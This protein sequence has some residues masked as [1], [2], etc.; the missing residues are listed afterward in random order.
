MAEDI[1]EVR[2]KGHKEKLTE[3]FVVQVAQ[4]KKKEDIEA[5]QHRATKLISGL[6]VLS[7][8][9]RLRHTELTALVKRRERGDLIQT[10]KLLKGIDQVDYRSFF[11]LKQESI[12]RA[13]HSMQIFK[14]R[15]RLDLRK[16][17]FTNRVVDVWN[18]LPSSCVNAQSVTDFK[19]EI[20]GLGY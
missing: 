16:H 2:V 18:G 14:K 20:G 6:R 7:Y 4:A 1:S 11:Q 13:S 3:K 9:D 10:F 19:I 8:E 12:T 17:Y 5:V 15:S